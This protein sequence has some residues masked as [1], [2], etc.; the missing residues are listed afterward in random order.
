[1][2]IVQDRYSYIADGSVTNKEMIDVSNYNKI[3]IKYTAKLGAYRE[4][5]AITASL[6]NGKKYVISSAS[7]CYV[8][9]IIQPRSYKIDIT[10]IKEK[11]YLHICV[12]SSPT[13]GA[14][15]IEV[16]EVWLEK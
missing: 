8:S 15:E 10:N 16:Y 4:N 11:V 2:R 7:L 1:M 13:T 14:S 3:C 9:P 12:K 5:E 6:Y